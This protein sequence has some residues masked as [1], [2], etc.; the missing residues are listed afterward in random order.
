MIHTDVASDLSVATIARQTPL[1]HWLAVHSVVA[2]VFSSTAHCLLPSIE[3]C[4]DNFDHFRLVTVNGYSLI[5][6][7]KCGFYPGI[8]FNC[9][10]QETNSLKKYKLTLKF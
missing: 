4:L 10:Y 8:H 3:L 5:Q 7:A 9:S 1:K 6:A 2:V